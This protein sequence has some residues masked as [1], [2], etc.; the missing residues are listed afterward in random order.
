MPIDI[1]TAHRDL[2][3]WCRAHDFAGYDPYDALNSRLFQTTPFKHSRIA[4]L[5]WTQL[6]K[7]SPLNWR[8]LALVPAERNAKGTALFALSAL[9]DYRRLRTVEA[10]TDARVLLDDLLAA[11]LT[12]RSGAECWGYNFDWQARSFFAPRGTPTVVP[13]AFAARALIEASRAF[14]DESCLQTAR[15]ACD[16]ILSECPRSFD[17]SARR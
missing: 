10:E 6:F 14:G 11:R 3:H 1:R 16:F 12:S 8:R 2:W 9:A 15:S 5:A 7:R 13:T 4:R 17:E